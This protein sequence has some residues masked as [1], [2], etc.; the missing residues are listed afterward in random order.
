MH[1]QAKIT[2]KGQITVPKKVRTRLGARDGDV[3]SFYEEGDKVIVS[4]VSTESPFE[5]YGGVHRRGKG[6]SL[7]EIVCKIR[8]MRDG[9]L[10]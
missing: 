9:D 5:K 2:S 3:I 4:R 8:E 10:D 7:D 6:L 1:E